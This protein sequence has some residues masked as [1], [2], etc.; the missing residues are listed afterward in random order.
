MNTCELYSIGY[1]TKP[2]ELFLEQLHQHKINAVADVRSVPYS[3]AFPD[4]R[5][6][7][8]AETLK[9]E[10]I[11]Y[12]YLGD[13]LGPRSNEDQYYNENNQIQFDRLMYSPLFLQGAKR[14]QAGLDKGM[15]IAIMCAEKDPINCH[16]SLL[17]GYYF[18]RELAVNIKHIKYEGNLESQVE[19]E[20]RL[21]ELHD[22]G[23]DLFSTD[24][25]EDKKREE[26]CRTQSSLKA[27]RRPE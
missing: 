27:Y 17:V 8:L 24:L 22:V 6:E 23:N 15:R 18:Q 12:V 9:A 2:I 7:S 13:E 19:M 4:Y 5:R 16:R 14:L 26:A 1:A 21:A 10:D 20:E 25:S 3:K 11:Y